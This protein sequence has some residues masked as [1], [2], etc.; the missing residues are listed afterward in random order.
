MLFIKVNRFACST[1]KV[2]GNVWYID[3]FSLRTSAA[4][5]KTTASILRLFEIVH[6]C[7]LC[8]LQTIYHT[9]LIVTIPS[10]V[11][12][13]RG[14]VIIS[15]H[16]SMITMSAHHS[17]II[18]FVHHGGIIMFIHGMLIM[19][20]SDT[21]WMWRLSVYSLVPSVLSSNYAPRAEIYIYNG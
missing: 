19:F 3:S 12:V 9:N 15:V 13:H 11:F 5:S 18:M 17:R 8:L 20:V 10:C 21:Q 2:G 1:S 7:S 14:R 6:S 4:K 16:H